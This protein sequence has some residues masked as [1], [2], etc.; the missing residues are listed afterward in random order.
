MF[1]SESLATGVSAIDKQHKDIIDEMD[2]I[3]KQAKTVKELRKFYLLL[4]SLKIM[5]KGISLMR[6]SFKFKVNILNIVSTNKLT[7]NL[8]KL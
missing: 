8:L 6:K 2:R 1:W 3:L 7:L 4:S 5:F